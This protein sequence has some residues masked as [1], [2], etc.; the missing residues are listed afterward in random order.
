M[1]MKRLF[2]TFFLLFS[3]SLLFGGNISYTKITSFNIGNTIPLSVSVPEGAKV[4]LIFYKIGDSVE[5]YQVRKMKKNKKGEYTY[6]L[7]SKTFTAKKL[8]YHFVFLKGR[9]YFRTPQTADIV[10]VGQGKLIKL[11]TVT[12]Q[13][14]PFPL[15]LSG[16]YTEQWLIS[17]NQDN[18]TDSDKNSKS[19]NL[20][21]MGNFSTKNSQINFSTTGNYVPTQAKQYNVSSVLF[22]YKTG[23]HD[24]EIGDISFQAPDLALSAYG[25]RGLYY[26]F[27]SNKVGINFFSL[28]SQ[29]ISGL[30]LPTKNSLITG[31]KI[32]FKIGKFNLFGFYLSGK[33]DPTAG[34]NSYYSS[35]T[36]REGST[37]ALGFDSNLFNYSLSL[38]GT[39]YGSNYTKDVLTSEKKKD[40]AIDTSA[41]LSY[42]GLSL[43]SQYKEIGAYYNSVGSSYLSNNQRSYGSSAS[44]TFSKITL[45]TSYSH[46][47]SNIAKLES[48]P[49]SNT[50][51]INS[52]ISISLG[53]ISLGIGYVTNKQKTTLTDQSSGLSN[54]IDT[55]NFTLN[56]SVYASS[57]FSLSLSGG[58]SLNK[59]LDE[60]TSYTF[61]SS[62]N[63]SIGNTFSLSPSFTYLKVDKKGDITKTITSYLSYNLNLIPNAFTI[64]GSASYN[65]TTTPGGTLNSK[66]I[67]AS[68]RLSLLFGW[69]WSKL[70]Q[71]SAY[72]EGS[73]YETEY[74]S[75]KTNYY[76][77][78]G[79]IVISF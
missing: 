42:K 61:N 15:S 4:V 51:N 76:K 27:T 18:L 25:K 1:R 79:S 47:E 11:P 6:S 64:S 5:Q 33:D 7:N 13:K 70:S 56:M 26:N 24:F 21:L 34:Q 59:S 40:H 28:S 29:Q 57:H 48:V 66:S 39:Y 74:P 75:V 14:K 9:E 67:N 60:Q 8:S 77:I 44:F 30:G 55:S 36:V 73:Y 63:I 69:I 23:K 68:S 12:P 41:S 38:K 53:K 46:M 49:E 54:T 3:F 20:T 62:M 22:K 50:N 52:N 10:A 78:Y 71:C 72:V 17:S 2:L 16:N 19:G 45:S 31:G 35:T 65:D 32:S 43:S 37:Y 58:K